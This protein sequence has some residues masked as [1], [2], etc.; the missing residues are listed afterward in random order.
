LEGTCVIRS[1]GV[2]QNF[3]DEFMKL[4]NQNSRVYFVLSTSGRWLGSNLNLLS[5]LF[6]VAIF[7][8]ATGLR[9][10]LGLT[11]SALGLLLSYI[12]QLT[13]SLQWTVRQSA[14]VENLMMSTERILEYCKL[15]REQQ[16]DSTVI[17]GK[18][19]PTKGK[20]VIQD[21][22]L[23]YPNSPTCVLKN[24]T[25]EIPAGSKVGVVG[26]SGAGKSSVIQALFR[27]VEP[28]PRSIVIDGIAT[29]DLAL[30]DLRQPLSIIPQ[31]PVC[32][33]GT[34]RFNLDPF[35][36]YTDDDIWNALDTVHLKQRIANTSLKLNSK[37]VDG[38][39]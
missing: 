7:F 2:K 27:L 14:E 36:K 15:K 21:M 16:T 38:C 12:L 1:F 8:L 28:N 22:S 24:M 17:P 19:W 6:L 4:Q 30:R 34:V 25:I 29:S 5:A 23:A 33:K 37:L 10:T 26:R 3:I 39:T 20:I 31:D 18:D 32:F 13:G 9:Q 11:P 35:A